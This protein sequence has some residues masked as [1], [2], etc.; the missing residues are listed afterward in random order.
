M[1]ECQQQLQEHVPKV[2]QQHK[3]LI[4]GLRDE[5]AEDIDTD[6]IPVK[7]A[8]LKEYELQ[9]KTFDLSIQS[10]TNSPVPTNNYDAKHR[11]GAIKR[12]IKRLQ[13]HLPIYARRQDLVEAVRS[14]R[15]V[16][17][18]ADTGS[19]KSTQLVQYLVDAGFANQRM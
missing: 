6:E 16:I 19:G 3:S 17:L 11:L 18:K 1:T 4:K 12:E 2:H 7:R 8:L 5:F 14:N 13:Y 10:L 15:V 9:M